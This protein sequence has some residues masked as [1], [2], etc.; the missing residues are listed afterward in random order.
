MHV[1]VWNRGCEELWGL[2]SDETT[3]K[4]LTSLDVGL[5][6]DE[7]RPLIGNAFVAPEGA[8]EALIEAVN[9]RGRKTRVRVICTSFKAREGSV[10]GALLLMEV[11]P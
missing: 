2:R 5:P 4:V 10:A 8:G 6:L 3:G 11:V 1:V 9:R 7:V